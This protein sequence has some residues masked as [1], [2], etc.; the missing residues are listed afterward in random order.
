MDFC[1]YQVL[2]LALCV[3]LR[4]SAP[5]LTCHIISLQGR[6]DIVLP[7]LSLPK[8]SQFASSEAKSETQSPVH[9]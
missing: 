1:A 8:Y 9:A 5:P 7:R 2:S 6:K 4:P 3:S